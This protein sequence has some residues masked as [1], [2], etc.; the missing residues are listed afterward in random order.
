MSYA[1]AT[2]KRLVIWTKVCERSR[3]KARKYKFPHSLHFQPSFRGAI[4]S[5]PSNTEFLVRTFRRICNNGFWCCV[6]RSS[7]SWVQHLIG[8]NLHLSGVKSKVASPAEL[9]DIPQRKRTTLEKF[10]MCLGC[11]SHNFFRLAMCVI[12]IYRCITLTHVRIICTPWFA[13]RKTSRRRTFES[14]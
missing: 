14:R 6:S 9:S 12:V 8:S 4:V 1:N 7:G 2:S 3:F 5:Y 11:F 10:A 13:V